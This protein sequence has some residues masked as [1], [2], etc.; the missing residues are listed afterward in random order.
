MIHTLYLLCA[1]LSIST[2]VASRSLYVRQGFISYN[3]QKLV[4]LYFIWRDVAHRCCPLCRSLGTSLKPD[5]GCQWQSLVVPQPVSLYLTSPSHLSESG[6][7]S[8]SR[9]ERLQSP[10]L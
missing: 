5:N 8:D 4:F 10:S 1:M 9:T 6:E 3:Y 7:G 2:F